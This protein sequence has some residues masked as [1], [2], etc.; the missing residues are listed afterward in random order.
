M[1][2]TTFDLS[3]L[4]TNIQLPLKLSHLCPSSQL[5]SGH[6]VT[7][8]MVL[9]ILHSSFFFIG[10]SQELLCLCSTSTITIFDYSLLTLTI[11]SSILKIITIVIHIED[12]MKEHPTLFLVQNNPSNLTAKILSMIGFYE[13]KKRWP[14]DYNLSFHSRLTQT[15][16]ESPSP[17]STKQSF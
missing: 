16:F 7:T 9:T 10:L 15:S 12:L 2:L 3:F 8:D 17:S 5:H 4:S 6:A 14:L 11:L 1:S 13:E